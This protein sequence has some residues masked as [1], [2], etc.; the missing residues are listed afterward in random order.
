MQ[1]KIKQK[2]IFHLIWHS[3][4]DSLGQWCEP[5]LL[6][7]KG[8]KLGLNGKT[9]EQIYDQPQLRIATYLVFNLGYAYFII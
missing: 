6:V 3:G 9:V 2:F 7:G 5:M 4:T 8:Y 1:E